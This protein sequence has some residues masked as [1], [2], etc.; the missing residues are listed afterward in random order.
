MNTLRQLFSEYKKTN[1]SSSSQCPTDSSHVS[2]GG[3]VNDEDADSYA[4]QQ[5]L[6]GLSRPQV[7]RSQ[8]DLYLEKENLDLNSDIDILDYW[9]ESSM[10]FPKLAAMARDLL[11]IPVS[12]VASGSTFSIGK[13]VENPWR[14]S[15]K[16]KIVQALVYYDDWMCARGFFKDKLMLLIIVN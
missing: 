16:S 4:Y 5:F 12:T 10:R 7:E 3:E 2:L 8:L 1:A 15:L 6:S 14:S 13:K 9:S 11:S